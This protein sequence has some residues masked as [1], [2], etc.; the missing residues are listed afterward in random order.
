MIEN[1]N[2]AILLNS[3]IL[4]V[5][6]V[7]IA[8]SGLL[9]TRYALLAL[10]VDDFG[11]FSVVG[12]IVSFIAIINTIML[13]TSNR[14][15]AVAIGKKNEKL[16]NE[17]FNVNL[18]IHVLI[19]VFTLFVAIPIGEWYIGNYIN[20]VGNIYNVVL[21]YRITV[22]GAVL[23]FIGVPYNGLLVAKERFLIYCTTDIFSS[24]LKAV[25]AYSLVNNFSDKLL[26]Y[27]I[28]I[29]FTTAFPTLVFY[30]YCLKTFPNYVRFKI[31]KDSVIYKEIF[32]FSLWVGYGAIASVGKSQGSA[33]IINNFFNTALNTA[34]G[35]ANSVNSLVLL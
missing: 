8:I 6:L 32:N 16:I 27:A 15:I 7:I 4:Y 9:T 29:S 30:L 11:I 28:A 35:V 17:T 25:V 21:V 24:I 19:A 34:L 23:S 22:V 18:V 33:L 31:V 13:S 10:G 12:S 20:Y 3:L 26:V 2:K 5:R 1:T 14:F